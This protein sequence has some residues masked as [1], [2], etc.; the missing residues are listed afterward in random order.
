MPTKRDR[1]IA[2]AGKI[3]DALTVDHSDQMSI[4]AIDNV[5]ADLRTLRSIMVGYPDIDLAIGYLEK[6]KRPRTDKQSESQ[7]AKD[8]AVGAK[9]MAYNMACDPPRG[10]NTGH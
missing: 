1:A 3:C 7:Q 10:P 6:M 2:L 5:I 9:I 8:A 4:G